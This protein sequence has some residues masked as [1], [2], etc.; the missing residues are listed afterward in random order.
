MGGMTWGE[1]AEAGNTDTPFLRVKQQR[2]MEMANETELFL[3]KA[4]SI[5][6]TTL[7]HL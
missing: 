3:H 7:D 4:H 5:F 6:K 2:T 1:K